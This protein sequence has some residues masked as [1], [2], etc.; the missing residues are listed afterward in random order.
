MS[1]RAL[2]DRE[3]VEPLDLIVDDAS[4][5][6]DD[7][8]ASFEACFGYLRPGGLYIVEDWG[9]AH[10]GTPE[11]DYLK[12]SKPLTQLL[13]D[14]TALLASNPRIVSRIDIQGPSIAI[15]TRGHELPHKA[16]LK[17]A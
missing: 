15:I 9:W 16:T 5:R 17:V 6:Y 10:R 4:H 12:G 1:L 14:L 2:L 13:S 3:F 7:A 11:F 8:R